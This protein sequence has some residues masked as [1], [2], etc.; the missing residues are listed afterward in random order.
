[1]ARENGINEMIGRIGNKSTVANNDQIVQAV[2]SG[3]PEAVADVMMAFMGGNS[4]NQD[5]IVENT[6]KVD[7]ETLY[8][9]VQKGKQSHD[10]RYH[11]VTEF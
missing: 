1:M 6:F 10:R 7:S 9:M 3:V 11:V 2:S 8:K 5:T 4:N